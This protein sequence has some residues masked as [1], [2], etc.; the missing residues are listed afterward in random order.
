MYVKMLCKKYLGPM[1]WDLYFTFLSAAIALTFMPGPDNI[2]VLTESLSKGSKRGLSLSAGL[3]SGVLVHTLLAASGLALI[4]QQMPSLAFA[5]KFAGTLYLL[6]LTYRAWRS[7]PE[8]FLAP[9]QL[10]S[11][12]RNSFWVSYGKG[13]LMNV[14][15]PKVTL[16]FLAL[17]PQFV[18]ANAK[19][20]A[21][22]QMV[23]MGF[24][25]MVQAF[26]IF[27]SIA[28]LAG[29]LHPYLAQEKF[30]LV[31]KWCQIVIL[32]FISLALWLF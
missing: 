14:L 30:W 31:T 17:L 11:M 27:G 3:S 29:K 4:L 26:L 20:S 21:F 7:K 10:K 2:F 16:F 22:S 12:R 18:S 13:F 6:F 15:N 32:L 19:Y 9:T 8:P 25:F 5:V 23:L 28:L 1:D 24:T